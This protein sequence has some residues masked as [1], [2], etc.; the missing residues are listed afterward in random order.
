MADLYWRRT[1]HWT[2]GSEL[3]PFPHLHS[4]HPPHFRPPANYQTC[5]HHHGRS[6][7][8]QPRTTQNLFIHVCV[9]SPHGS[10]LLM[11]S[12]IIS[13]NLFLNHS[14]HTFRKLPYFH[15]SWLPG[16][17][18]A[19]PCL[20]SSPVRPSLLAFLSRP[21]L[22]ACLPLT[23]APPCLPSSPVRPSLSPSLPPS[24]PSAPPYLHPRITRLHPEYL[25]NRSG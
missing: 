21:P 23:S 10:F 2:S 20:P 12:K 22:P 13:R 18:R 15:T 8:I 3:L 4:P 7:R 17:A 1:S 9:W 25:C 16:F 14:L 6:R 5:E 11:P 24:L 19:P